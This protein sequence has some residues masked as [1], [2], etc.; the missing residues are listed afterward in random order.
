MT[1]DEFG[2]NDSILKAISFMGFEKA[3]PVQEKAIPII[4]Q[5]KDLL[6]TSSAQNQRLEL[7]LQNKRR[8]LEIKEKYLDNLEANR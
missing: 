6:A 5:N 1:F 7:E 4:L 2:L 3:T 8:E